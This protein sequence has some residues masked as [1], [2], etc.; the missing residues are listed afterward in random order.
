V[1][2]PMR[3]LFEAPTVAGLTHRM[4]QEEEQPGD[5]EKIAELLEQ[6]DA[7]SEE[8]T[9]ILLAQQDQPSTD[10]AP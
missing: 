7:L 9:N 5:L 4:I 8:D 6:I 3:Y 10:Y 2:L 1:K